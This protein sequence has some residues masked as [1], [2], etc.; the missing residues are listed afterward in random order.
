MKKDRKVKIHKNNQNSNHPKISEPVLDEAN[1]ANYLTWFAN[2]QRVGCI[3]FCILFFGFVLWLSPWTPQGGQALVA[4]GIACFILLLGF[5]CWIVNPKHGCGIGCFAF[6]FL[7]F[8][9]GMYSVLE[10]AQMTDSEWQQEQAQIEIEKK[11]AQETERQKAEEERLQ[12][13]QEKKKAEELAKLTP[14][15]LAAEKGNVEDVKGFIDKGFD[16]NSRDIDDNTPLHYAGL[17][18]DVEVAKYLVSNG[19]S[20]H[21]KHVN[22]GTPLH[23][24]VSVSNLAVVRYLIICGADVKAENNYGYRPLDFPSSA[25]VKDAL[26]EAIEDE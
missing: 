12:K 17:N 19:A 3:L 25:A 6:V 15:F 20:V 11:Q 7:L 1:H 2:P 13:E 22:G 9:T 21:A 14:F 26:Y 8:I 4:F 10:R 5:G 16:V 18:P 23:T 24:A